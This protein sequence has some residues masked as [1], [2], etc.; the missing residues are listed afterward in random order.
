MKKKPNSDE[1][2]T[3]E[4]LTA[5][6]MIAARDAYY[7]YIEQDGTESAYWSIR[8]EATH[9]AQDWKPLVVMTFDDNA[10]FSCSGK[11]DV[12]GK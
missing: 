8:I 6:A 5:H 11:E 2:E 7:K 9:R 1:E 12:L 10:Q 4:E 3:T